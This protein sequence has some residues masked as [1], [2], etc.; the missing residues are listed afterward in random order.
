MLPLVLV[1]ILTTV[2]F[3]QKY[4]SSTY[5]QNSIAISL[6]VVFLLPV[7]MQ[8]TGNYR[9]SWSDNLLVAFLFLGLVMSSV[10]VPQLDGWCRSIFGSPAILGEQSVGEVL[11]DLFPACKKADDYIR[12]IGVCCI[13][14]SMCIP[15]YHWFCYRNLKQRIASTKFSKKHPGRLA[16]CPPSA[17]LTSGSKAKESVHQVGPSS[18]KWESY[19]EGSKATELDRDQLSAMVAVVG[20]DG[21]EK[22]KLHTRLESVWNGTKTAGKKYLDVTLGP[23]HA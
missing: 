6:V 16:F 22:E 2:N 15:I 7:L 19:K 12:L 18:F 4:E 17:S 13:W 11:P 23:N 14:I 5:L 10:D 9:N 3:L 20:N 21:E 8:G 1:V